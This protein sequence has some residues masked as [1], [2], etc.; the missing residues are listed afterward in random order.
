MCV[1]ISQMWDYNRGITVC[2]GYEHSSPVLSCAFSPNGRLFVTGSVDGAII[3]WDVPEVSL[4]NIF[5]KLNY[6]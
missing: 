2:A 6:Y 1:I 3:I 5:G 4:K